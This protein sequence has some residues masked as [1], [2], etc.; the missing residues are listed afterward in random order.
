MDMGTVSIEQAGR[1]SI[2]EQELKMLEESSKD[3]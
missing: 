3:S 1:T 2:V